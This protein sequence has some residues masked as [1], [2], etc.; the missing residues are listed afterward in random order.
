MSWCTRSCTS[1]AVRLAMGWGM[2]TN[3]KSG[4]PYTPAI[5]WAGTRNGSVQIDTAGMP[6]FSR[7]IPSA[8]LAAEQE[9]QS[10]TPATAKSQLRAISAASSASTGV[11][12][13][14]LV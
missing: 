1:S 10:P 6:A 3:W 8:R 4:R 5:A 13:Y 11:P 14:D 12:K 2:T 9:P 7:M